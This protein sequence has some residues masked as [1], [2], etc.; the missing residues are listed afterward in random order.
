LV[1]TEDCGGVGGRGGGACGG[2]DDDR[3]LMISFAGCGSSSGS[4][5]CG[6]CEYGLRGRY[7]K[8]SGIK[9]L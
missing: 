3:R 9:R 2:G 8:C 6:M 7:R 4:G 1:I 5:I